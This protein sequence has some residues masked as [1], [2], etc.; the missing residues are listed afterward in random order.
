MINHSYNQ[1]KNMI[2]LLIDRAK[3]VLSIDQDLT[4]NDLAIIFKNLRAEGNDDAL[5]EICKGIIWTE[6]EINTFK[7]RKLLDE[8]KEG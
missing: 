5:Y 8:S 3:N 6:D 1:V 2:D 4:H 7:M